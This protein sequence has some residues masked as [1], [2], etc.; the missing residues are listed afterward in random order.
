MAPGGERHRGMASW[1]SSLANNSLYFPEITPDDSASQS[2]VVAWHQS[3]SIIWR[4]FRICRFS[5]RTRSGGTGDWRWGPVLCLASLQ[6]VLTFRAVGEDLFHG[7]GQVSC[8]CLART[9]GDVPL[10]R[11]SLSENLWGSSFKIYHFTRG[12]R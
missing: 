6:V 5:G 12:C 10:P 4:H 3:L 8:S 9:S 1:V 11:G 2:V 7:L